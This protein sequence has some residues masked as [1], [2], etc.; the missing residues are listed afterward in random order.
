MPNLTSSYE[1]KYSST[2]VNPID[3]FNYHINEI[4]NQLIEDSVPQM[5]ATKI[6][7]PKII[8]YKIKDEEEDSLLTK[9]PVK[10]QPVFTTQ[11]PK[12]TQPIYST[13]EFLSTISGMGLGIV[14]IS[15]TEAIL[16]P[17]KKLKTANPY[18]WHHIFSDEYK[19]GIF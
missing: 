16:S 17:N 10:F 12:P 15:S 9:E 8:K 7:D 4:N 18:D 5:N 6:N 11:K 2:T 1:I 19:E 14:P 3:E 13:F